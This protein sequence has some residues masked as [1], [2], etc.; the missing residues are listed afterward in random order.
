MTVAHKN[1]GGSFNDFLE[2]EGI[3]EECSQTAIKRVLS[4][5]IE[6]EMKKKKLSKS[7]MARKMNTSRSSLERLLDPTNESVTLYTL[8]KAAHAIGR[9]VRLELA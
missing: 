3:L 5:Q 6:Q 7:A 8:K 2:E 1:L 4:W 9:T